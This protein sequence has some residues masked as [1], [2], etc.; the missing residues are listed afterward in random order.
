MI[1]N[2]VKSSHYS[3]VRHFVEGHC[4]SAMKLRVFVAP[5]YRSRSVTEPS[6]KECQ[7]YNIFMVYFKMFSVA[8]VYMTANDVMMGE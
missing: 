8:D 7:R 4:K 5:K 6:M 3:Y 2:E 1:N